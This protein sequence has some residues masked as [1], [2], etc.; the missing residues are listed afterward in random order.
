[1]PILS[2]GYWSKVTHMTRNVLRALEES[3][4]EIKLNYIFE[5]DFNNFQTNKIYR[6]YIAYLQHSYH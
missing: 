2:Y 5:L 4:K 1:M 6:V 3:H